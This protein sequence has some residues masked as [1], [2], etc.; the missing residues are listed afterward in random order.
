MY[1][2]GGCVLLVGENVAKM[3]SA[4]DTYKVRAF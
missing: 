3:V 2:N 4:H 1:N